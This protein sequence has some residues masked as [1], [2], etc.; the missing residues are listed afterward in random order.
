MK[1]DVP[2]VNAFVDDS[3]GGNP[4]GIDLNA[5]R[6]SKEQKQRISASIGLSE[7]AF[8]SPS[9]LADFKLEFFTPVSQSPLR[10]CDHCHLLFPE[11]NWYATRGPHL[12]RDY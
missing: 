2:I 12:Q 4:A 11:T 10:S 8:V 1:I 9:S 6:F 5:Q 7:T 3:V